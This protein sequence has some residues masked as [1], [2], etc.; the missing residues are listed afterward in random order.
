MSRRLRRFLLIGLAFLVLATAGVSGGI[1]GGRGTATPASLRPNAPAETIK[2]CLATLRALQGHAKTLRSM[3][4][5]AL[6]KRIYLY[7]VGHFQGRPIFVPL[8]RK[9]FTYL[10]TEQ[11]VLGEIS[12][13]Q[14]TRL[15]QSIKQMTANNVDALND[16]IESADGRVQR[17]RAH[18][19]SLSGGT[20]TKPPSGTTFTRQPVDPSKDVSNTHKSEL[21]IDPAGMSAHFDNRAS[22]GAHWKVDYSWEVPQTITPGKTYEITLHIKFLSVT[23]SQPLGDQMNAL[24]PDF[25]QAIQAHW[26]DTPDVSKTFTVT[27]AADQKDSTDIPI[28]IGFVSSGVTYH[29]RK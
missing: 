23:P 25:A 28:T 1:A 3:R 19:A 21:T 11:L 7:T 12:A 29:Y 8:S 2:Q 17:Q 5:D 16:Y 22:S 18:C 20:T 13:K 24:A 6:A 9:E 26:P 14:A 27:L 4:A 15:I 10:I